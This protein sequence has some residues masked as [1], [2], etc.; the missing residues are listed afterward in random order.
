MLM[1][2]KIKCKRNK[3]CVIKYRLKCE[4]QKFCLEANQLEERIIF[5]EITNTEKGHLSENHKEFLK[6]NRSIH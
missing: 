6:D 4:G 3:K 2:M 1:V 5:L